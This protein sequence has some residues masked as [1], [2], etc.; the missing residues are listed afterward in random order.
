MAHPNAIPRV[1]DELA[2]Y[3][4]DFARRQREQT[5][6]EVAEWEEYCRRYYARKPAETVDWWPKPDR[7][8]APRS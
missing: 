4:A 1:P 3:Y 8:A 6:R 7:L 2:D 5:E